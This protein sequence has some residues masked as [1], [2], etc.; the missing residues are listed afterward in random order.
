M[1]CAQLMAFGN[2][3]LRREE[4]RERTRVQKKVSACIQEETNG[5]FIHEKENENLANGH[6]VYTNGVKDIKNRSTT[7]EDRDAY[8]S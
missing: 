6:S 3:S 5:E 7:Y 2:V 4:G 1:V 8:F